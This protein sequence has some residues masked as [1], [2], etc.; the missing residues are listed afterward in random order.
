[1]S[2]ITAANMQNDI[3]E[4]IKG[5]I[6]QDSRVPSSINN[7]LDELDSELRK[8]KV[9]PGHIQK[10]IDNLNNQLY[11]IYPK[12]DADVL[13]TINGMTKIMFLHYSMKT[14]QLRNF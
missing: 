13:N 8:Q 10:L 14:T 1:M 3:L 12:I 11:D 7:A 5:I 2:S 4:R 6:T 9:T